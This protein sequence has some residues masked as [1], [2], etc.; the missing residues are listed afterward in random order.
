[1]KTYRAVSS[2]M[3][4]AVNKQWTDETL[5]QTSSLFGETWLN[6]LT[7]YTLMKHEIHHRG[8]MT[9]LIR[10]AGLKVPDVYGPTLEQM[11]QR[12]SG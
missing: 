11:E 4:E 6:G 9:V 1:M 8:Q 2:A 10:Q 5:M 3:Q 12:Y 7:L